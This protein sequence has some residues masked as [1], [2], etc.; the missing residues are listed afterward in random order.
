VA[1]TIV[2]KLDA[3]WVNSL[4]VS[5]RAVAVDEGYLARVVDALDH[6]EELPPLK[7]ARVEPTSPTWTGKRPMSR[8]GGAARRAEQDETPWSNLPPLPEYA[9]YDGNSGY[10][11]RVQKGQTHERCEV[12]GVRVESLDELRDLAFAANL[13]H[14]RALIDGDLR[15]AFLRLRLGREPRGSGEDWKPGP[16]GK[17]VEEIAR[18]IGRQA[19]WQTKMLAAAQVCY[20]VQCDLPNYAAYEISKLPEMFWRSFV[21]HGELL[22]EHLVRDDL[23]RSLVRSR[24]VT[25]M[26]TAQVK[27]AVEAELKKVEAGGA[28][29]APPEGPRD[30][31]PL[32]RSPLLDKPMYQGEL[33]LE[34]GEFRDRSRVLHA[35]AKELSDEQL[36]E[37]L[38]QF[39][40]AHIAASS[41]YHELVA[42]ARRRKLDK[43]GLI[44]LPS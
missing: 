7:V 41:A 28:E 14:G 10:W 39:A 8:A 44:V 40:P 19:P 6:G 36:V 15:R 1:E 26:T 30:D 33:P 37:A 35:V 2:I 13:H 21:W 43:R 16:R 25:Q 17:S 31:D 23:D 12:A 22:R 5:P 18:L 4:A 32:D 27:A 20:G 9:L 24:T 3:L 38:H 11:A 34:W 29:A 42:E